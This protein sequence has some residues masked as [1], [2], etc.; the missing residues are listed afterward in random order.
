M[1]YCMATDEI[2]NDSDVIDSRDIIG[3]IDDIRQAGGN[4]SELDTLIALAKDGANYTPDM[5]Y[6]VILIRD[7]YF[8]EYAQELANDL[9][10]LDDNPRWPNN[11][12]DWEA[13]AN[14]LK[15]DYAVVDFDGVD[16]YVI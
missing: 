16:Y 6:G 10:L 3:R 2:T 14:E 11:H 12:I 13:A 7:T 1:G 4:S 15:M 5:E 9:G 8:Q